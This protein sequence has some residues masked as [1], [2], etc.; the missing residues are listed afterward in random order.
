MIADSAEFYIRFEPDIDVLLR[1]HTVPFVT[2]L[3]SHVNCNK[4]K[5]HTA[6]GDGEKAR[7]P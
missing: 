7:R 1:I 2:A 5:S 6:A 3:S 4:T